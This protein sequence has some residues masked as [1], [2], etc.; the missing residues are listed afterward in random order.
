[1]RNSPGLSRRSVASVLPDH[2]IVRRGRSRYIETAIAVQGFNRINP[3]HDL[4]LVFDVRN[5]RYRRSLLRVTCHE[6]QSAREEDKRRPR[7]LAH[8]V[9]LLRRTDVPALIGKSRAKLKEGVKKQE[10]PRVGWGSLSGLFSL[11][12]QQ[13]K[14]PC[15]NREIYKASE[16]SLSSGQKLGN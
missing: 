7:C 16:S 11:P 5:S 12:E 13:S 4:A 6:N 3:V 15:F 9:S 1:M 2:D 8:R 14:S 10:R